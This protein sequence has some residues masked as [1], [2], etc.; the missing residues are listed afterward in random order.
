LLLL[1]QVD[2]DSSTSSSGSGSGGSGGSSGS[3]G[4]G[5]SSGSGSSIVVL[6]DYPVTTCQHPAAAAGYCSGV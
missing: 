6:N 3:G 4:S 2:L 1:G 5:G